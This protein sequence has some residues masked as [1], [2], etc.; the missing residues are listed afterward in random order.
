MKRRTIMTSAV[1]CVVAVL[2]T[3][4]YGHAGP[5]APTSR[6]GVVSV[7]TAFNEC[8]HQTQYRAQAIAKQNRART[9]LEAKAQSIKA[10]EANLQT[11]KPGTDD[12]LKQLQAVLQGRAELDGQ[13][14][15]LKQQRMAEDK[16]WMEKLY[17]E[18]LK[19]VAA[20]AKEKGLDMVLERTDP[21]FPISSEEL[22]ATFSTHK[23]LYADGCVDLTN[24]VIARLDKLKD[25]KP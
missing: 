2:T 1:I 22:M 4:E 14:E 9:E 17:Q 13:Q 19:I 15:F 3:F 10:A 7:R 5:A 6:I 18:T 25:L 16:Q 12:Y 11:L 20:L 24:E 8:Q 21:E 23:V